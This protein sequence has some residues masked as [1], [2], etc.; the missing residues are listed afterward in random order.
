LQRNKHDAYNK[1]QSKIQTADNKIRAGVQ[2]LLN[3]TKALEDTGIEREQMEKQKISFDCDQTILITTQMMD[4]I[5]RFVHNFKQDV[6][7]LRKDMQHVQQ[8]LEHKISV[9][10]QHWAET[11]QRLQ[12]QYTLHVHKP[13]TELLYDLTAATN[14]NNQMVHEVLTNDNDPYCVQRCDFAVQELHRYLV[15]SKSESSETTDMELQQQVQALQNERRNRQETLQKAKDYLAQIQKSILQTQQ[16][17]QAELKET[18]D[19]KHLSMVV[20][21]ADE[22]QKLLQQHLS[23]TEQTISELQHEI[24]QTKLTPVEKTFRVKQLN[25]VIHS[26]MDACRRMKSGF[27][28]AIDI[29]NMTQRLVQDQFLHHTQNMFHSTES[30]LQK[31]LQVAY[32]HQGKIDHRVQSM[33]HEIKDALRRIDTLN[34]ARLQQETNVEGPEI[35]LYTLLEEYVDT[36]SQHHRF[37]FNLEQMQGMSSITI[38]AIN[39]ITQA[40]SKLHR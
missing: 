40:I 8:A 24:K 31:S 5:L 37:S 6:F 9:K 12:E 19:G 35:A 20:R 23:S 38:H 39:V 33:Q 16:V 29:E 3:A 25:K 13:L 14:S 22:R 1:L 17:V 18:T 28:A 27:E 11:C 21:L 2:V 26:A 7:D 30:L 34:K 10:K 15:E 4:T 32:A 36:I